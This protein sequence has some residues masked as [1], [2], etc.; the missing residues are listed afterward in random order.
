[1]GQVWPFCP[2]GLEDNILRLYCCL[3]WV[4]KLLIKLWILFKSR[5]LLLPLHRNSLSILFR[6][7]KLQLWLFGHYP[8]STARCI[9]WWISLSWGLSPCRLRGSIMRPFTESFV[10]H[11]LSKLMSTCHPGDEISIIKRN[12]YR[13]SCL[14][15]TSKA[16][17]VVYTSHVILSCDITVMC[18]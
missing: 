9:I 12:T 5:L 3:L 15:L 8:L 11:A 7:N 1:M 6:E 13:E 2:S 14:A 16:T 10:S 17:I 4:E 18:T